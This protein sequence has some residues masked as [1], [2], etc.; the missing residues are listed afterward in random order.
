VRLYRFSQRET[1]YVHDGRVTQLP[2]NTSFE[3][4]ANVIQALTGTLRARAR[5]DYFSDVVS[6][7]LYHQNLYQASRRNRLVEGGVTATLGP[8][9]TTLS[10]R[11]S[12]VFDS[13]DRRDLYGSTPRVSVA[14]APQRLFE[15]PVYA[16]VN[17]E[18]AFLPYRRFERDLLR[19]DNSLSRLDITPT[20]RVPLSRLTFLSVTTSAAYRTTYY[21]RSQEARQRVID[22]PYL[23]QYATVRSEVVG[24]VFTR[25]WDLPR[26]RWAARLK[27]VVEPTFT[28]D[29]TSRIADFRRVPLLTDASDVVVG[30]ATRFTYGLTNR[31]FSRAPAVDGARRQTR[32]FLTVGLQQTYYSSREANQY[33]PAYQS[34]FGGRR[35]RDL[36]PLALTVRL[37]PSSV[38]DANSRVEYDVSGAG[39]TL[40]SAGGGLRT[41]AGSLSLSYSHRSIDRSEDYLTAST[42]INA[43]GGRVA[44]AYSVS[45]DISRG[46]VVNQT[47]SG[48][49][50]AQCCG[51]LAEFQQFTYPQSAG[52]PLPADRR[53]NLGVVLAGLGTFSNF[54]GAFG[55]SR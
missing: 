24:P 15:A 44:G 38:L 5:V 29:F 42:T 50:M 23:R 46:Y 39:L 53:V 2:E 10:Y 52:F 9:S 33:D 51:L 12:E 6:Q 28:L 48:T 8:A 17:G 21:S 36:S 49:Y 47:V 45:W 4:S 27:H 18:Y 22:D 41:G 3:V 19:T 30:G 25:I 35:L 16:S 54:F 26:S 20:L 40:L 14:L 32:E 7:Q 31:F 55:G 1:R 43:R 37:S 13:I 11:R 34:T